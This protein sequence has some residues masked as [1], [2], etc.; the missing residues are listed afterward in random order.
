M[1]VCALVLVT[2]VFVQDSGRIVADTKLDLVISPARFLG[3]ALHLW[4]PDAAF[5][6]LQNQAYGYFFPMG[7]FFAAAHAIGVP[8]WVTQRLWQSALLLTAF[9]GMRLLARRLGIG[10]PNTQLLAGLLYALTPLVLAKVGPISSEA[11][12]ECIAPW[13]L[14]PLVGVRAARR[15]RLAAARS[16]V[17]VLLAGGI[18]AAATIALL[19]VPAIFLLC[20]PPGRTR[21]R[22]LLW[23]SVAIGLACLWWA[24]PLAELGRYSPPFL[25]WIEP[26]SLTTAPTGLLP[27]LSGTEH[28]LGHLPAAF[29]APW[30]SGRMLATNPLAVLDA[31][32]IG[33]LG[34]LGLMRTDLRHRRFLVITTLTGIALVTFGH[35]GPVHSFG[36]GHE[37]R[38]LDGPLAAF[39][40]VH[41]FDVVLRVPLVLAAAHLATVA[42]P[43]AARV[44]RLRLLAAPAAS[45]LAV[46]ALV[47]VTMPVWRGVLEP[48]GSFT[49]LPSW[50]QQTAAYLHDHEDGTRALVLPGAPH[51]QFTWGSPQ[52]EPIQALARSTWAVRDV[53]PLGG[54]G[55]VRLLDALDDTLR[56]GRGSV[57]LTEYLARAGVGWLVVRNDL[58]P[59]LTVEPTEAVRAALNS[60]PGIKRVGGFGP[61]SGVDPTVQTVD[62]YRVTSAAGPVT[63]Y[64]VAASVRVQGNVESLLG[65]AEQGLLPPTTAT[66]V[67]GT[68]PLTDVTAT[69]PVIVTDGNRRTEALFGQVTDNRSATLYAGAPFKQHRS[70][71]Q[72]LQDGNTAPQPFAVVAGADRV[73]ASSSAADA[74]AFWVFGSQYVPDAAFDGNTATRWVSG[75][76]TA[77]GQWVEADYGNRLAGGSVSLSA[78]TI[79]RAGGPA[80]R[81]RVDTDSG[82]VDVPVSAT[83]KVVALPGPTRRVRATITAV[84]GGGQGL[85]ASIEVSVNGEFSTQRGLTV[86]SRLGAAPNTT[87]TFAFSGRPVAGGC[88]P[89]LETSTTLCADALAHSTEDAGGVDRTFTT[90]TNAS[91]FLGGTGH[92]HAGTA[93][94]RLLPQPPGVHVTA[95]STAQRD[96]VASA[97]ALFDGNVRTT[98]VVAANDR[99]PSLT[100]RFDTPRVVRGLQI[101]LPRQADA[102]APPSVDVT[103][104]GTVQKVK[105]ATDGVVLLRK[106]V[107]TQSMK[108]NFPTTPRVFDATGTP[109][110]LRIGEL[111]LLFSSGPAWSTVDPNTP[112]LTPCGTGPPLQVD[113][114]VVTTG[115][116]ARVSDVLGGRDVLIAPCPQGVGLVSLFA[117]RHRIRAAST[118]L[119]TPTALAMRPSLAA[120]PTAPSRAVQVL[121]NNPG[122]IVASIGAG[123]AVWVTL[124]QN[125]NSGWRGSIDGQGLQS[126]VV[127]GWRQAFLLPAGAAG[128]VTISFAPDRSYA[129]SLLVG[130]AAVLLLLALAFWRPRPRVIAAHARQRPTKWMTDLLPA[131]VVVI[132]AGPVGAVT[133]VAVGLTAAAVRRRR[134]AAASLLVV[135]AIAGIGIGIA[136]AAALRT[137]PD[138][139]GALSTVAQVACATALAAVA[140][141]A[142]LLAAGSPAPVAHDAEASVE[143]PVAPRRTRKRTPAAE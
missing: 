42:Q 83:P 3:R 72:Y 69:A 17:A 8:G 55:E 95:S 25:S 94:D 5:G 90:P 49:A 130:A 101:R 75:G 110:H 13:T 123:P 56:A 64:P 142:R 129:I 19:P 96:A 106:P 45:L 84:A 88:L 33:A 93:L 16:G 18:N 41:K 109:L 77:V 133:V 62:V 79:P 29:G 80:T 6:Q 114:H 52:D 99:S 115:V 85:A 134:D 15:P 124:T 98:W 14:I 74:T 121:D 103:A 37:Q 48:E 7:P 81:V 111:R 116:V 141:S 102:V 53:V 67:E 40:N 97:A 44:Q 70:T 91:Y 59:S 120:L 9:F 86:P 66:L 92:L 125:A 143:A 22:M 21:R 63:T 140:V 32:V 117:G 26:S 118:A 105:L 132:I 34:L 122:Q 30:Q 61:R 112:I 23:W 24:A 108:L 57:A 113:D 73:R 68:T 139:T 50:W 31:A 58:A 82:A 54:A 65:L 89:A 136:T 10:T 46:I 135:Q 87:P 107:R 39:R 12:V 36:A 60:S 71:H 137:L 43:V 104:G 128:K 4:S 78:A 35:T 76:D 51:A 28:W 126:T 20:R 2:A 27:T 138:N 11:L 47:G 1:T 119:M 38:L 131:A 127:D 100:I